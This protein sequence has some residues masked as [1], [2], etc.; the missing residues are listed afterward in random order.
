MSNCDDISLSFSRRMVSA[1]LAE[2]SARC[3]PPPRRSA[4]DGRS[5]PDQPSPAIKD[6]GPF[7]V[8]VEVPVHAGRHASQ[9]L[10]GPSR[11]LAANQPIK[12]KRALARTGCTIATGS[13]GH[14]ESE[15]SLFSVNAVRMR[16][17]DIQNCI[18]GS[19]VSLFSVDR[20]HPMKASTPARGPSCSSDTMPPPSPPRTLEARAPF[21]TYAGASPTGRYRLE[22]AGHG[23]ASRRCG[24]IPACPAARWTSISCPIPT[25]CPA[26]RPGRSARRCWAATRCGCPG[27]R[28]SIIGLAVFSHWILDLVVH[29]P[30]RFACGS[31]GRR[32]GLG[33]GTIRWPRWRRSWAW[34]PPR[35][36]HSIARRKEE[37]SQAPG[38]SSPSWAF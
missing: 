23:A 3:G 20:F 32:W 33:F 7:L 11:R 4:V 29:R 21:L 30:G 34:S 26:R 16:R 22:R 25:A 27:A 12:L 8:F 38:R 1:G 37:A 9:P 5:S 17:A 6:G 13:I 35:R 19:K 31:A 2:N 36:R 10:P 14:S 15:T 18:V 24:S 28:R